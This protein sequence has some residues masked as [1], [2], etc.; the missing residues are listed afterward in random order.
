MQNAISKA[1]IFGT[2]KFKM[3]LFAVS[4]SINISWRAT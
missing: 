2:R 1:L 4:G 3:P